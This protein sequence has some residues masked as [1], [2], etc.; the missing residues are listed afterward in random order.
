MSQ[1]SAWKPRCSLLVLREAY[2]GLLSRAAYGIGACCCVALPHK[3]IKVGDDIIEPGN[4]AQWKLQAPGSR[5][6]GQPCSHAPHRGPIRL[7]A[8]DE[9]PSQEQGEWSLLHQT[10]QPCRLFAVALL[11]SRTSRAFV[12]CVLV[13]VKFRP[14]ETPSRNKT[15]LHPSLLR[16]F[17]RHLQHAVGNH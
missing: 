14:L 13:F 5:I 3:L 16:A 7:L 4:C 1:H 11:H 6:A 17:S 10:V 8:L 12:W 9:S 15:A 2:R